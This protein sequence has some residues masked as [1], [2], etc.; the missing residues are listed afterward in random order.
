MPVFDRIEGQPRAVEQLRRASA[1]DRVAHAWAFLGPAGS[2]RAATAL[3]F[4][5][6]LVCEQRGCGAC[7]P[8]RMVEAKQHPDV[9]VILPTPPASNPK[10][11]RMVRIDAVR[12]LEREA[13]LRP[14]MAPRKVFIVTEVDRMTE[15]A[16][17]AFLKTLEEPPDRTVIVLLLARAR[18]VPA[19]VLSRCHVVRFGARAIEP[20]AERETARALLA[21]AR[22]KGIAA[23]FAKFD[24]SRPDRED[25][26]AIVDAWW[27]WCRDL[28]VL[29]AGAP[30][31]LLTDPDHA[32]ELSAEAERWSERELEAAIAACR[33][34]REGLLVNVAPR[35]TLEVLLSRL[36]LK[37]A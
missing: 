4:A 3:A 19:T 28:M 21:D 25:A 22:D 11:A 9:H 6:A 26:E 20:P 33:E 37:V 7:R 36:A 35:L 30:A 29:K 10:G 13:S 31:G 12:E 34:A 17:Q 24:R 14:V 15:D 32:A 5:A 2:G 23:V 18:S 1:Q 16:P 8:C 27:H